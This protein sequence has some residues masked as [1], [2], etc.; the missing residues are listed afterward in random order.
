MMR[1]PFAGPGRDVLRRMLSSA[2]YGEIA[3]RLG[4]LTVRF[5][6]PREF[7]RQEVVSTPLVGLVGAMDD[8]RRETLIKD[9]EGMLSRHLDDD[10]VVFPMQTWLVTAGRRGL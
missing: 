10:G 4:V 7:L 5:D 3:I 8:A 1:A 2:G 6:S 9:L